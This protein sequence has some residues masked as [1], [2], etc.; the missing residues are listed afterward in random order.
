M[1]RRTRHDRRH[2]AVGITVPSGQ[3]RHRDLCTLDR[4]GDRGN[5]SASVCS[6]P[7]PS[8]G[9]KMRPLIPAVRACPH[10]RGLFWVGAMPDRVVVFLDYQNIYRGAR[11]AFHAPESPHWCGQI[12][13][14]ILARYLTA[15]SPF[16]RTL[17]EVRIYRGQPDGTRDPVGYAASRRQIAQ[18]SVD[19]IAK[20]T[21][22]PLRY[23]PDW[24]NG[25]SGERPQ[26]KGIDVALALDVAVMAMRGEYDVGI[27]VST[28]T[29]LK[30][31]LE[32]VASLADPTGMPRVEVAA[33]SGSAQFSQRLSIPTR[34]IYCHWIGKDTYNL[35][36]DLTN[37]SAQRVS[38]VN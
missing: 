24:P 1:L 7:D 36:V 14:V 37:F 32:F 29:D 2:V 31:A 9:G 18:W 30:P 8:R 15:D 3:L 28:D 27:V 38:Q 10:W 6:C 4:P 5:V 16:D 21:V 23:P 33:W 20:L 35:V 11:R 34:K 12:H 17:T 26:E 22:R 25:L 19:S 13:P